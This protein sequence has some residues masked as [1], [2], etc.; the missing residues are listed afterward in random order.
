MRISHII[1]RFIMSRILV[2]VT[3]EQLQ[4]L[5]AIVEAEKR[6]RAVVIREA[7]QAYIAQR[8]PGLASDT[9]GLWKNRKVDGLEYQEKLREEW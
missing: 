2:D 5:T 4:E 8:K 3:E 7:I 1:L 6:P 9:F